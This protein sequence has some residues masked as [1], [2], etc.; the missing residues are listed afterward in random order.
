MLREWKQHSV[1]F[2]FIV[3]SDTY[4]YHKEYANNE[5]KVGILNWRLALQQMKYLNKTLME[6]REEIFM[7]L[8]QH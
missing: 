2:E 8:Q 5:T 6:K 4:T 3:C 7:E 1:G